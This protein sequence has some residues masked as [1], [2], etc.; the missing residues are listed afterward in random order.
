MFFYLVNI[1]PD[2][3]SSGK[4]RLIFRS[5]NFENLLFEIIF[6]KRL[7]L[8]EQMPTPK[9]MKGDPGMNGIGIIMT[10]KTIKKIPTNNKKAFFMRLFDFLFFLP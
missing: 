8:T 1:G 5:R 4:K 10:P 2:Y 6:L 3:F 7:D 9:A